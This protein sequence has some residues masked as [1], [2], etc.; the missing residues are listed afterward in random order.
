MTGEY[1]VVGTRTETGIMHGGLYV[2]TF[3][4]RLQESESDVGMKHEGGSEC[5]DNQCHVRR[6][7]V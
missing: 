2:I 3:G 5:I 1:I 4:N 6:R 7:E